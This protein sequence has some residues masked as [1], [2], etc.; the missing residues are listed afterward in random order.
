ML[1]ITEGFMPYLGYHTYYRMVEPETITKPPLVLLHGGPGSTHNYFELLDGLAETGRALIMYDQ[2]GCGQ[3][4]VANRP[5]LWHLDTWLEELR[6][7]I[8][9]L[10]LKDFHLLGQSWGGMLAISY[11]CEDAPSN[12]KSAILSSTLP[13]SALWAQE[14]KRLIRLMSPADQATIAAGIAADNFSTPD[15]VAANERFMRRHAADPATPDAPEPLRRAKKSG[16]EAYETAW[17]PNEFYP[18]GTLKDWDYQAQLGTITTPTLVISGVDDLSTPL[19]AKTLADG[20]PQATWELFAASRHL[21]LAQEP[22]KYRQV[23]TDWLQA[24]D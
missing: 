7:L 1:K 22:T 21:P 2:L 20:I 12:L 17:G 14:Q 13:S 3:S 5:D 4:Y 15:F 23:L 24:H 19:V 6:A 18:N 16:R 10:N 9:H 8:A 11:L